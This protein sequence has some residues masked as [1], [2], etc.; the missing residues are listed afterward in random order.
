M[1]RLPS[2]AFILAL[3]L[4]LETSALLPAAPVL[5]NALGRDRDPLVLAGASL[6]DLAGTAPSRIVA[7]RWDGQWTQI[8]VQVD[9]RTL[10]DFGAIYDTTATG[11][12]VLAY[13]DTSTFTGADP[14]PFFD[15][16]D[17]LALRARDLGDAPASAG[18]PPG[19]LPGSGIQLTVTN[20]LDGSTG[21]GYLFV[22]DG[23]LDPA[24]G[25]PTVGYV[26]TLLSGNYQATYDTRSGP[27]PEDSRVATA[28]YSVHFSDRWIRDEIEVTA[29]GA[30]GV[31]VLDRHKS[32]FGPG[33]CA[34]SENTFS[35]SEGAFMMN[36]SG[37]VRALR[38]YLGCNSGPSS[39]RMHAFYESREDCFTALRVHPIPGIMDYFD[40]SPAAA[41][42]T[43]RNNLNLAGVTVDGSPD[44]GVVTG[45][46]AWEMVSGGQGTLVMTSILVTDIQG[47]PLASYY[48]DNVHPTVTQCTGDPWEYGASGLRVNGE[49]PNTDPAVGPAQVLETWRVIV[50]AAPDQ[51][52]AFAAARQAEATHPL[53]ATAQ[54]YVPAVAVTDLEPRGAS[55]MLS[56]NPATG[57]A[58]ISL[59]LP[60][61]GVTRL[62]VHDVSGRCLTIL[63]EGWR[64]A[65]R[66][67]FDWDAGGVPPGL[68]L[69]RV[70]RDGRTE[71]V[72]RFARLR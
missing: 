6:A 23:S 20:P 3:A 71:A 47:L 35:A 34:R 49:I 46:L 41:G 21:Y 26:F 38:G 30:S 27:N 16:D 57:R 44:P 45:P 52:A 7:F 72:C 19:T 56:P 70:S 36:R 22:S 58:R 64:D 55:L 11:F 61:A 68:Y 4:V 29:G 15:A 48:S 59:T 65:G 13:A 60:R 1:N 63:A 28:A 2:V 32:L 51:D 5:A 10:V 24:A 14:D 25:L 62:S 12:T 54:P 53:V 17:E 37:P 66:H 31:D 42:M 67:A 18:E 33:N 50:Y 69:V 43:Y 8:P 40:Y 39:W 9:E